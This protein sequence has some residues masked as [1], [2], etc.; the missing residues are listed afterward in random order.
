M[1]AT[2]L[3]FRNV[4]KSLRDYT[5]Y[6]L[7]L[8][9]G[10]CI[11]YIFNALEG[12]QGIINVTGDQ[13]AIFQQLG[14]MMA[15]VSVFISV[16]LGFLIIYANRF[17]IRRRKKEFGIYLTLGLERGMV[18]RILIMETLF[19]GLLSLAVGLALGLILSQGMALVTA[20]L[21]KT[22]V[23]GF[24]FIFSVPAAVKAVLYFGL[25]F[26]LVLI[27]NT[28]TVNRL[29]LIDLL[30]ANRKNEKFKT[31]HLAVSV[32]LFIVS[33][34]SIGYAYQH[35]L[36]KGA[37]AL[38][39]GGAMMTSVI[40]GIIGTFLFFFSLAGFFLKLIQQN[41]GIYLKNLN[42]FTLRQLNSKVNT[43]YISMS[44]ICIMLFVSICTLS[45]GVDISSE[46]ASEQSKSAPFDA[47]LV[48][49]GKTDE[50]GNPVG[51]YPGV[52][53]ADIA[54]EKGLDSFSKD[55]LPVRYYRSDATFPL[56][57]TENNETFDISM[58][59]Y[60]MGLS[61]YNKVLE[62]RGL[63]KISLGDGEYAVNCAISNEGFYQA[64]QNYAKSPEDIS[65]NGERLRPSGHFLYE[66]RMEVRENQDYMFTVIVDDGLTKGLP[67]FK[68]DLHI[69][70]IDAAAENEK[71][72]KDAL[73]S[74]GSDGATEVSL[75]TRT[76]VM[77]TSNA[78][79]T[80]IT[81][82]AV[83][84]GVIFLITAAAVLA[85]GQLSETSDNISRYGLLR[86]I[87]ADD[88]MIKRSL[89]A[90]ILIY[91]G[92][93]MALALVHSVVGITV[94]SRIVSSFDKGNILEGSLFAAGV[95]LA[96]YGGYFLSTYQGSKNIL[97]RSYEG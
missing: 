25:I 74:L 45:S 61:E 59:S 68:D 11:F 38:F 88:K 9:F 36:S 7:T 56:S 35:I 57:M 78:A 50:D 30:Y 65:V 24:K 46:I 47:T 15:A 44:M 37:S 27:F 69:N 17:L 10:V 48:I 4:R 32:L 18:S 1:T 72:C 19:V 67:V 79:T 21:L 77:A 14:N 97:K 96:V 73:G 71:L 31:P 80:V 23:S 70:Y 34:A 95:I 43:T 82:L 40:F 28:M 92:A 5:V 62:M 49:A 13:A 52:D 83:Y 3:A 29:K 16:I 87:G 33:L 94:T 75:L 84:L 22:T 60:I 85:I 91:F 76:M 42:I 58:R 66:N 93:P 6:F 54:K 26:L 20:A 41:K 89:F 53:I 64:V 55:Y 63:E 8:T 12:Q 90:Q 39:D 86:K 2:K 51:E 81:Y